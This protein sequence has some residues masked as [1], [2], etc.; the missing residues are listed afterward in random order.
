MI[1]ICWPTKEYTQ[2]TGCK[3]DHDENEDSDSGR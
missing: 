1:A 3:G 2:Y